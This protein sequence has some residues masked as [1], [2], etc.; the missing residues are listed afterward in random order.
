MFVG[1]IGERCT[2]S[3]QAENQLEPRP[4]NCFKFTELGRDE[5][6]V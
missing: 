3:A 2:A 1:S 6:P 5:L 4:Y